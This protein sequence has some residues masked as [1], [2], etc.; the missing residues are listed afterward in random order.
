MKRNLP[1]AGIVGGL[2]IALTLGLLIVNFSSAQTEGASRARVFTLPSDATDPMPSEQPLPS[3]STQPPIPLE[4]TATPSD[5]TTSSTPIITPVDIPVIPS[6]TS[7]DSVPNESENPIILSPVSLLPIQ[8]LSTTSS[9]P[10]EPPPLPPPQPSDYPVCGQTV[11]SVPADYPT[12][13]AALD[14]AAIGDTVSVSA[15]TYVEHISLRSGICLE[16]AGVD[17]TIISKRGAPGITIDG[18]SYVIV[19]NLTVQNSGCA[20]G[21]CGGGKDG[22]GMSITKSSNITLESCHLAENAAVNGGGIFV[23]GSGLTVLGCLIEHNTAYN[24]GGAIVAQLNTTLTFTNTTVANNIWS[25]PLGNG[26][27]GGIRLY[28]SSIAK[29]TDSSVKGNTDQNLSG[30]GFEISSSD[31]GG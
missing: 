26:G 3:E 23:S 14:A 24:I 19:K 28:D 12:I 7:T 30:D 20:P 5:E 6:P 31:I 9:S 18:L 13:Q 21:L 29:I 11:K 10:P 1:Y 15:G 16:G 25:N 4:S 17:Q 2:L 8:S 22:G 27:V